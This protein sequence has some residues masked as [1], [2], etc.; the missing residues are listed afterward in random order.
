[1]AKHSAKK[2][3]KENINKGT[4]QTKHSKEKPDLDVLNDPRILE[5]ALAALEQ[6]YDVENCTVYSA[7]P[8]RLRQQ[9]EQLRQEKAANEEKDRDLAKLRSM[10]QKHNSDDKG[11]EMVDVTEVQVALQAAH[12]RNSALE[13]EL[14][15]LKSQSEQR[16]TIPRPRGNKWTLEIE[17]DLLPGE[18]RSRAHAVFLMIQRGCRQMYHRAHIN[19]SLAWDDVPTGERAKLL[20]ALNEQFPLLKDYENDWATIAILRQYMKNLRSQAYRSGELEVP[21]QYHYLR[22]NSAKRDPSGSRTKRIKSVLTGAHRSKSSKSKKSAKKTVR[23]K[24]S[25]YS[26][27]QRISV[28]EED[29]SE[30]EELEDEMEVDR[31]GTT[32]NEMSD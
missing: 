27:K 3:G 22:L 23:Q 26:S 18:T 10:L 19:K 32:E 31:S 2:A 17:M 30:S 20:A 8:A 1:M 13:E 25:A 6:K 9:E 28:S 5:A 15:T 12:D 21:D 14:A 11:T 7:I 24:S 29:V 16:Q 4:R